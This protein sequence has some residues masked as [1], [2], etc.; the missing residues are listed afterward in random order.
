MFLT[1]RRIQQLCT[2]KQ[3][4]DD[5]PSG[6]STWKTNTEMVRTHI[7]AGLSLKSIILRN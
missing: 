3:A 4:W 7:V 6:K 1:Q 5:L 2:P